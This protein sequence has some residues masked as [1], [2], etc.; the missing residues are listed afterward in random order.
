VAGIE[1]RGARV[2]LTEGL[3][4]WWCSHASQGREWLLLSVAGVDGLIGAWG[5]FWVLPAIDSLREEENKVGVRSAAAQAKW[6]GGR[7]NGG[8][9]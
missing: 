3:Q 1:E 2:K 7:L 5:R 8:L 4:W 6:R 9:A